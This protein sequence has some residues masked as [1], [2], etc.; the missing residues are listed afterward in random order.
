[1]STKTVVTSLA[2]VFGAAS[3]AMPADAS[4]IYDNGGPLISPTYV[5]VL[6]DFDT[7]RQ[8]QRADDF[9]LFSYGNTIT[10]IQWWG[11]YGDGP[12]PAADNFTIRIF[13]DNG[14]LPESDPIIEL[15][16]GD[17]GRTDSGLDQDFQGGLDVYAYSYAVSPI[18]LDANTTYWLSIVNDT[19]GEAVNWFWE[20]S[21]GSGNTATRASD[22]GGWWTV[23]RE[24][25]FSLSN[26]SVAPEPASM[27]LMGIGLAG[28]GVSRFRR[29]R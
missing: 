17:V 25:A 21:S 5:G 2:L 16:A 29:K 10:E 7:D 14:G 27:L 15:A 8:R 13:A 18:T 22:D 12:V 3:L 9:Q 19:S 1:M 24:M 28:L 23:S 26:D 4:I 11:V 6:S 20:N